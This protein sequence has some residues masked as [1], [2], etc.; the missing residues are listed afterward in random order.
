VSGARLPH[1]RAPRAL[2]LAPV[3]ALVLAFLPAAAAA[4]GF[5]VAQQGAVAAGM[6]SAATAVDGDAAAAWFNP[7]AL[8]DGGGLRTGLG[9]SLAFST[10]H[11]SALA[12][13]PDA[14]WQ[15]TTRNGVST[16]PYLHLS[17]AYQ[18]FAGGLAANVPFGSRVR[19]ARDWHERFDIVS[20]EPQFFRVAP[21]V[22]WRFGPVRVSAGPHFDF[23][24]L[25]LEKA[26]NHVDAEGYV[27][28]LFHG[29]GVGGDASVYLDVHPQ[30]AVGVSYKSR[31]ALKLSGDA[32]FQDIPVAFQPRFPD[33]HVKSDWTL[34]DRIA[35]GGA[36][37]FG[38]LRVVADLVVTLWSVNDVLPIDF[39]DPAT[40]DKV[41]ENHWRTTFAVRAGGEYTFRE[42]YAV[43]LGLYADGLPKA[44]PPNATLAPS[45]PDSTRIA[46]TLGGSV[47][48]W[49]GL[50]ADLFYEYLSLLERSSSSVDAP[51]A[52]YRGDAHVLG[53]GLRWQPAIDHGPRAPRATLLGHRTQ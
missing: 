38:K 10:I 51:M 9:V 29:W 6:G 27:E 36:A 16:P 31:T 42:R 50:A 43:R 5:E 1:A 21:F 7:A 48:L 23:G 33:Q 28:M 2:A 4:A 35:V 20:S 39:A 17:Y 49:R 47:R 14:P 32:D 34:P 52:K 44:A 41:Q 8:A 53:F 26:T 24:T 45:S 12:A 3:L 19:W 30:V 15:A 25:R 18:R 22:A 13:A 46:V 37:R 11:A 40:D